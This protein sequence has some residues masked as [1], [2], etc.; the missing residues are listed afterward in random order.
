MLDLPSRNSRRTGASWFA[1]KDL[2]RRRRTPDLLFP[3]ART[4]TR[5]ALLA[6]QTPVTPASSNRPQK[7][8]TRPLR[9]TVRVPFA[10]VS[11]AAK[12]AGPTLSA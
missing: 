8:F 12:T 9:D 10:A 6:P 3:T 2:S 4:F 1:R 11:A 5:R 7:S